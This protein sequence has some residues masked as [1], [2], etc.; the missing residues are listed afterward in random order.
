MKNTKP[1]S[2]SK[3][4][5]ALAKCSNTDMTNYNNTKELRETSRTLRLVW[6]PLLTLGDSKSQPQ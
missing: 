2:I 1:S 3:A 5:C 6:D 4:E